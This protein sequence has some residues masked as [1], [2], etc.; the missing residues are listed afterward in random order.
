V[1]NRKNPFDFVLSFFWSFLNCYFGRNLSCR[2]GQNKIENFQRIV[3]DFPRRLDA[4][5]KPAG[6]S[7]NRRLSVNLLK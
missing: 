2:V 7:L 5:L 3:D 1:K 4:A 6:S